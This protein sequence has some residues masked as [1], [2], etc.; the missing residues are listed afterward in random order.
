MSFA[1]NMVA[2]NRQYQEVAE[3]ALHP[4]RDR[5]GQPGVEVDLCQILERAVSWASAFVQRNTELW[6]E[7][8]QHLLRLKTSY[9]SLA[10][11]RSAL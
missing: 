10:Q 3:A 8:R 7:V 4:W 6:S 2:I 5:V 1:L 9:R 11:V